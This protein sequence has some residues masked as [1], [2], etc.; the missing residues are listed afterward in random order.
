VKIIN[1]LILVGRLTREPELKDNDG[2]M[3]SIITLAVK[4]PY[5][6]AD[7]IYET[8]FINCTVW[9]VI[10]ERIC[11]YCHKGDMVSVKGRVVSNN[12]VKSDNSKVYSLEIIADQI[13]F[14]QTQKKDEDVTVIKDET[15]I[16]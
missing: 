12:Y 4:R 11:E 14:L 13:S 2:K 15:S 6:N 7:G 16:E 1:Q 8:D 9:N 3:S 5:K 10:A